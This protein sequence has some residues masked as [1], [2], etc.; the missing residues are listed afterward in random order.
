MHQ[1]VLSSSFFF[2]FPASPRGADV[3]S[4][5]FISFFSVTNSV[6]RYGREGGWVGGAQGLRHKAPSV[7]REANGA[8]DVCEV[9]KFGN[10]TKAS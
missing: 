5:V 6:W 9:G 8:S 2:S 7:A 4:T 1:D 3:P 10:F